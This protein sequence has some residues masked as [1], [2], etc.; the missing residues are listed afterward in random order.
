MKNSTAV[1]GLVIGSIA[2]APTVAAAIDAHDVDTASIETISIKAPRKKS[3]KPDAAIV[4]L[5]IFLDRAGA[6]PG[7][8]DGLDGTNLSK[9]IS[10]FEAMQRLPVDGK[11]D[12]EVTRRLEDQVPAIQAYAITT[13]DGND[14]V[15]SI[16]QDYSRQ[17]EMDHLSYTSIAEKLAER[18]H[19]DIG[20]IKELNPTA[21]FVPGETIAVAVPGQ[22][23]TGAAQR[24][25]VH[26]KSGQV[27]AFAQDGSLLAVYPATIGSKATPSP[28]GT[29]KVKG[30]ARMPAYIYNPKINFQQGNNRK[31]LKLPS[32][33]N[34][35]VGTVW[36]D[37]TE[38]TYGIHGTPE[39][40]LIDKVGSHGCVRLTNWDVEELAGMVKP[41]VVAKFMD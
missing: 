25:E 15:D 17:A 14:L 1:L 2:L 11:L 40:E 30:V 10:G 5:Q 39:P 33:P 38:P 6:S 19:M 16:P 37:L 8:I 22:V 7:V 13:D 18:F 21:S 26:R 35:P 34:N 4:K 12:P 32:G 3:A 24:L 23:R 36:I 29:H 31:I 28:T 41:G 9:A 27:F 20:L